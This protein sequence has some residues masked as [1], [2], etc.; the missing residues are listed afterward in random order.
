[1]NLRDLL[2]K[3]NHFTKSQNFENDIHTETEMRAEML[4]LQ[5]AMYTASTTIH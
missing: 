3:L 1:M 4:L 2:Y 5:A